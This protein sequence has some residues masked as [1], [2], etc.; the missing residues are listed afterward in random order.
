MK[1]KKYIKSLL[2]ALFSTLVIT[3]CANKNNNTEEVPNNNEGQVTENASEQ[4][5]TAHVK[6]EVL[7]TVPAEFISVGKFQKAVKEKAGFETVESVFTKDYQD[8]ASSIIETYKADQSY[9]FDAPLF[10]MNPYGTNRTGVYVYFTTEEAVNV[11]YTISVDQEGIADYSASLY[12]NEEGNPVTEHEGQ[13]IGLLPGM[14]NIVTMNAI[15]A[16]GNVVDCAQFSFDVPDFGTLDKIAYEVT[17]KGDVEKLTD[18]LFTLMDYD[19]QDSEEYSHLIA[20]DNSGVV[21]AE[22]ITDALKTC[23]VVEFVGD[24][25]VYPSSFNTIIM[26]NRTGKAERIYDLGDYKYHHDMEYNAANNSIAILAD[27]TRKDTIEEIVISLDL[28]SGEVTELMDFEDI[29]PDIY[30]RATR[31]EK[32]MI[33]G[34]EFDW[35]HF[36]SI[37]FINDTDVLLSSRELSSVIRMNDIYEKPVIGYIIADAAIWEDTAYEDLV[38]TKVGDF[39]SQTGQHDL[40][41][42]SDDSLEAGQYYVTLFNNNFAHSPTWPEYDWSK[43]DGVNLKQNEVTEGIPG[44]FFYKYLVDDNAGVYTLV[45][46]IELPYAGFVSNSCEYRGNVVYGCGVAATS[47][48]FGETDADGNQLVQFKY[49]PESMIGAYRAMKFSYQGFW[50]N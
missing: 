25:M 11:E 7:E 9:T 20:V 10:I 37:T 50:F 43:M 27:D 18:G 35:I 3:G 48:V 2:F 49:D 4:E 28:E 33:F 23:P 6:E 36:N 34:T 12:S 24:Y 47:G 14:T 45:S 15:D 1:N 16:E 17:E 38:L 32:N 26:V 29:M 22:L 19:S 21:R 44:S 42:V 30:E 41:I 5:Q 8:T 13:I 46:S 31:P 39:L 40:N